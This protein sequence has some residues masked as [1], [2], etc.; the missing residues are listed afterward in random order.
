MVSRPLDAALRRSILEG[1]EVRVVGEMLRCNADPNAGADDDPPLLSLAAKAGETSVCRLLLAYQADP[2]SP[3]ESELRSLACEGDTKAPAQLI[4]AW[5]HGIVDVVLETL[6]ELIVEATAC[7]DVALLDRA[8]ASLEVV[9]GD[10]EHFMAQLDA[11]GSSLFHV[12]AE[13]PVCNEHEA[14]AAR[15][16]ARTLAGWDVPLNSCNLRGETPL[17]V[18]M[19]AVHRGASGSGAGG[20]AHKEFSLSCPASSTHERA[21]ALASVLLEAGADA[22]TLDVISGE[23][24]LMQAVREGH[25]ASCRLLVDYSADA[26]WRNAEHQTPISLARNR[27]DILELLRGSLSRCL[28]ASKRSN[29]AADYNERVCYALTHTSYHEGDEGFREDV[30]SHVDIEASYD[31]DWSMLRPRPACGSV[32]SAAS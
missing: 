22:D 28:P 19:R 27:P 5:R 2:R 21:L 11:N 23:T 24:L 4:F 31:S 1:A 26:L 8:L 15:L 3:L 14:I 6:Q 29:E 18:A 10:P 7:C 9:G 16:T 25:C 13:R 30:C 17:A 20:V 12:C 32:E